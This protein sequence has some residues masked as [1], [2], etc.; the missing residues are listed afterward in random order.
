M[1]PCL[2]ASNATMVRIN[3][4]RLRP[5]CGGHPNHSYGLTECNMA[6]IETDAVSHQESCGY[7]PH[8]T[9]VSIEGNPKPEQVG[10]IWV[11]SRQQFAGYVGDPERTVASLINGWVKTGDQGWC[12][13][14]G[15][16][17]V[18]GRGSDIIN[19]RGENISSAEVERAIVQL[20]GVAEA[21]VVCQ[22]MVT[23]Q[24]SKNADDF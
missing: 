14:D 10:E 17:R 18:L 4:N 12:N 22:D 20:P 9:R 5:I 7:A 6:T 3:G 16:R 21:A 13:R 1:I 19:R 8:D 23:L 15:R 24:E 11:Q 2:R